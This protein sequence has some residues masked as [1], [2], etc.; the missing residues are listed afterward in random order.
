MSINLTINGV[1]YPFPEPDDEEWGQQVL[2]W[3]TAVTNSL[4]GPQIA[5]L[6]A[7]PVSGIKRFYINTTSGQ[8]K[9]FDGTTAFGVALIP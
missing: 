9:F 5:E 2:D 8:L 6:A 1:P 7:D 3:A 4:D